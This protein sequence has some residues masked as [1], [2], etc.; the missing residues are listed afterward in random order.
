MRSLRT[1][2]PADPVEA[3]LASYESAQAATAAAR[4]T[5][6]EAERAKDVALEDATDDQV[7]AAV[8]RAMKCARAVAK[9]E[10]EEV[11]ARTSLEKVARARNLAEL[12]KEIGFVEAQPARVRPLVERVSALRVEAWQIRQEFASATCTSQDAYDRASA[13]AEHLR[14]PVEVAR[15]MREADDARARRVRA[16]R[17]RSRRRAPRSRRRLRPIDCERSTPMT[18]ELSPMELAVALLSQSDAAATP[19]ALMGGVPPFP[20]IGAALVND[21][22]APRRAGN[23]AGLFQGEH[24]DGSLAVTPRG[25]SVMSP[26]GDAAAA[27]AEHIAKERRRAPV[28]V[29]PE[30]VVEPEEKPETNTQQINREHAERMAQIA[31][32][33]SDLAAYARRHGIDPHAP[34]NPAPAK[35]PALAEARR[36]SEAKKLVLDVAAAKAKERREQKDRRR[37]AK[38]LG[39]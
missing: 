21:R 33:K 35:D 13:L 38:R 15:R 36:L 25:T 34:I 19:P 4:S 20:R 10:G 37:L 29:A 9:A 27:V 24:D 30:P 3:A 32:L 2:A 18:R 14:M 12:E 17:E 1:I 16:S 39:I 8:A 28:K 6:A 31:Q 22:P 7:A 11:A 5:L 23:R 26:S